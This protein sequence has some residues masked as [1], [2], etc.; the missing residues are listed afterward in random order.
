MC[1][2]C[3]RMIDADGTIIV[4][5]LS[6]FDVKTVRGSSFQPHI[7]CTDISV[8]KDNAKHERAVST[9]QVGVFCK[10][11]LCGNPTDIRHPA[12]RSTS[13]YGSHTE[14]TRKWKSQAVTHNRLEICDSSSSDQHTRQR[15]RQAN[16]PNDRPQNRGFRIV[17][18]YNPKL[19]NISA[20]Q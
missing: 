16:R 4:P 11:S 10:A 7:A 8:S 12:F 15:L 3:P 14:M 19:W 5:W 1:P 9:C 13:F 2:L 18:G 6:L 20:L 17:M